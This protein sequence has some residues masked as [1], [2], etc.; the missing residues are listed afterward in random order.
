L[1]EL[2]QFHEKVRKHFLH[3]NFPKYQKKKARVSHLF[4]ETSLK[5]IFYPQI[6]NFFPQKKKEKKKIRKEKR[7]LLQS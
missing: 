4:F 3:Q 7:K 6:T 5:K 1:T 2:I